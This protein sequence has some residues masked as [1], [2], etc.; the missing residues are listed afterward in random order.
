VRSAAERG[1]Q[2]GRHVCA[3]ERERPREHV[4]LRTGIDTAR[5]LHDL[6]GRE[7][8]DDLVEDVRRIFVRRGAEQHLPVG[9]LRHRLDPHRPSGTRMFAHR[10]M[11]SMNGIS[12]RT[13]PA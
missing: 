10:K 13:K 3:Q 9:I 6:P 12:N 7:P 8:G 5:G 2:S 1:D 4:V 11:R